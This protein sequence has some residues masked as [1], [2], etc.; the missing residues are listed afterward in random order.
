MRDRQGV[1]A[2]PE[3]WNIRTASEM[4]KK[5]N[6]DENTARWYMEVKK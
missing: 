5:K 6:P 3:G 1:I 2:I 4:S